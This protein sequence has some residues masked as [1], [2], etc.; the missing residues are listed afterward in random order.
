MA[1]AT[2]ADIEARWRTLTT[3]E[4]TKATTLLG[5]AETILRRRV[6]VVDG[7]QEQAAA[8]KYVSCNMVVRAMVAGASDALGVDQVSATMGPFAQT[9]HYSNP[10]GDL[11]VTK[12]ER[13][14]LGIGGGR[15]RVLCPTYG[16]RR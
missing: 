6:T 8:L 13:R 10:N 2:Y 9:A 14:L 11:Y 3:D 16:G 12:N 4:Q 1:F 15:G 7:D 5:D